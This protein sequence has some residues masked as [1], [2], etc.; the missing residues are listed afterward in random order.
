MQHRQQYQTY[1]GTGTDCRLCAT[2]VYA[3]FSHVQQKLGGMFHW[4]WCV[5]LS[6]NDN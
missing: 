5:C 3:N 6:D 4:R 1:P 2:D